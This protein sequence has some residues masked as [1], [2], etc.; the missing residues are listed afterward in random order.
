MTTKE[1]LIEA[2]EWLDANGW[3]QDANA[4]TADRM[5]CMPTSE[6]VAFC[7]AV[8]VLTHLLAKRGSH[9]WT[10]KDARPLKQLACAL[11]AGGQT[12]TEGFGDMD[13]VQ[14]W[15]DAPHRKKAEVLDLFD[16]AIALC[17][18]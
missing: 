18:Q 3:C 17:F 2:R 14:R 9:T 13:Q 6:A 5:P 11:R 8:G 12:D 7:C 1:V 10:M 4:R 16:R 15:N